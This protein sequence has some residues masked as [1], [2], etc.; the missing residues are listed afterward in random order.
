MRSVVKR[1]RDAAHA[2]HAADGAPRQIEAGGEQEGDQRGQRRPRRQH[3]TDAKWQRA[4]QAGGADE[5]G[6]QRGGARERQRQQRR[7]L[8][9][10]AQHGQCTFAHQAASRSTSAITAGISTSA[11]V[12]HATSPRIAA[13]PN[14]QSPWVSAARSEP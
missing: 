5:R 2:G 6:H 13:A 10:R 7:S 8:E 3:Q 4:G 11:V 1:Q 9:E 14:V 12:R